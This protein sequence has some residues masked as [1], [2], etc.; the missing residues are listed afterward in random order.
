MN[1]T[2]SW[3]NPEYSGEGLDVFEYPDGTVLAHFFSYNMVEQ[4]WLI[5]VGK[6]VGNTATLQAS[7]TSGG[8]LNDP[9]ELAKVKERSWGTITLT[10]KD[11]GLQVKFNGPGTNTTY[12][13]QPVFGAPVTSA[14]PKIII[15][16]EGGHETGVPCT[17]FDERLPGWVT[18]EV[19][20]GPVTVKGTYANG[21]WSP[22][23]LGAKAGDVWKTGDKV[24][25]TIDC[26]PA[27]RD[28]SGTHAQVNFGVTT[29]ELGEIITL[30][31]YVK[32]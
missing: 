8:D 5:A 15:R 31:G 13:M 3:Y 19:V 28:W 21:P 9:K 29:V 27:G 32:S 23:V 14:G 16:N 2:N 18:V 26:D 25:I 24:K 20:S 6:R 30:G 10:E 11:S 17:G 12:T 4:M 7:I 22:K 1:W